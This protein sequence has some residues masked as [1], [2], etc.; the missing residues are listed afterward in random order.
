MNQKQPGNDRE[1]SK[2]TRAINDGVNFRSPDGL[3]EVVTKVATANRHPQHDY[4]I[5]CIKVRPQKGTRIQKV[6]GSDDVEILFTHTEVISHL[7]ALNQADA[8]S[9]YTWLEIPEKPA[10]R[11]AYWDRFNA[12]RWKKKH[13]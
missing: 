11:K 10:E 4:P 3:V 2:L 1:E 5:V 9:R 6:P 8:K 13:P 12:Q 7:R